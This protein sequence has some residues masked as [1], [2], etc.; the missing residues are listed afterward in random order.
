MGNKKS[1]IAKATTT[2]QSVESS[3]VD[4]N[5]KLTVD[6]IDLIICC[7]FRKAMA[8]EMDSKSV[9]QIMV[10]YAIFKFEPCTVDFSGQVIICLGNIECFEMYTNHYEDCH[11]M[12]G[13]GSCVESVFQ[14]EE[15]FDAAIPIPCNLQLVLCHLSESPYLCMEAVPPRM[16]SAPISFDARINIHLNGL[17]TCSDFAPQSHEYITDKFNL[18]SEM[19]K[20]GANT[21]KVSNARNGRSKYWIKT[22]TVDVSQ[23]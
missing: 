2:Q 22:L 15:V 11:V 23:E 12:G 16:R 13:H 8:K 5:R 19:L 20:V 4:N 10:Q 6:N 14:I 17:E 1:S 9:R 3:T 18:D 21:I 7:I